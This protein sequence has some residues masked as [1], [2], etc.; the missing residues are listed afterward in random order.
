[1]FIHRV[2]IFSLTFN[3]VST[4]LMVSYL[5]NLTGPLSLFIGHAIGAYP[6]RACPTTTSARGV[7]SVFVL[8]QLHLGQRHRT[9]RSCSEFTPHHCDPYNDF[10]MFVYWGCFYLVVAV[11]A[12]SMSCFFFNYHSGNGFLSGLIKT[13][14]RFPGLFC[15]LRV[16]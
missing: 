11:V 8:R 12:S 6:S 7:A 1:M 13:A 14:T 5:T 10:S 4:L 9:S 15:W 16:D 3:K 2:D